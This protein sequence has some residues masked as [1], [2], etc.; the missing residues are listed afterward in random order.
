[1]ASFD[2]LS[3][4]LIEIILVYVIDQP[5]IYLVCKLWNRILIGRKRNKSITNFNNFSNIRVAKTLMCVYNRFFV[6]TTSKIVPLSKLLGV[7][8]LWHLKMVKTKPV[9]IYSNSRLSFIPISF[10]F[11][12]LTYKLILTLCNPLM[13]KEIK[14]TLKFYD[15]NY[16]SI[17]ITIDLPPSV[18]T[19]ITI[20]NVPISYANIEISKNS[21]SIHSKINYYKNARAYLMIYDHNTFNKIRFDYNL[22]VKY[23]ANSYNRGLKFVC[24]KKQQVY[25]LYLTN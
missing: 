1:M 8:I 16:D 12:Y 10:N 13:M 7:N 25:R 2:R 11:S 6:H 5:Y 19:D 23:E 18:Q 21:Q 14:V 17:Q 3:E 20:I 4:E 9:R 24:K 22:A 15:D